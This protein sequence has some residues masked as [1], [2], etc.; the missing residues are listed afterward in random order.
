MIFCFPKLDRKYIFPLPFPILLCS[1]LGTFLQRLHFFL[2]QYPFYS[3]SFSR[4]FCKDGIF[5]GIHSPL[6]SGN[7]FQEAEKEEKRCMLSF[8]SFSGIIL[9]ASRITHMSGHSSVTLSVTFWYEARVIPS[10]SNLRTI[11]QNS[12]FSSMCIPKDPLNSLHRKSCILSFNPCWKIVR[13][14]IFS[15]CLAVQQSYFYALQFFQQSASGTWL[16]SSHPLQHSGW[17]LGH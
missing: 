13:K 8:P 12:V 16:T 5:L 6:S 7:I 3:V 14:M 1:L 11:I 9:M 10:A 4:L 15:L 17:H 2:C